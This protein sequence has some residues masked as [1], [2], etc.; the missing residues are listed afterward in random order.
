M[1]NDIITVSDSSDLCA[2]FCITISNI[3][4]ALKKVL[5]RMGCRKR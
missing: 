5:L 2:V 1:G 3:N 4:N